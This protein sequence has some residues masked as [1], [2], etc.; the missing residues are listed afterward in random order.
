MHASGIAPAHNSFNAILLRECFRKRIQQQLMVTPVE[1]RPPGLIVSEGT[2]NFETIAPE[3]AVA[4]LPVLHK[5]ALLA[6]RLGL[7][8]AYSLIKKENLLQIPD[9]SDRDLQDLQ[10]YCQEIETLTGEV[11]TAQ[12]LNSFRV[13]RMLLYASICRGIERQ[14]HLTVGT[15]IGVLTAPQ[16]LERQLDT[17]Q[18]LLMFEVF[19]PSEIV[20]FRQKMKQVVKLFE[21]Y[22]ELALKNEKRPE[23]RVLL[24]KEIDPMVQIS[25]I[26]LKAIESPYHY[27]PRLLSPLRASALDIDRSMAEDQQ[28]MGSRAKTWLDDFKTV[29]EKLTRRFFVELEKKTE[30]SSEE[31]RVEVATG[32]EMLDP[33]LKEFAKLIDPLVR[34]LI[35]WYDF[36][37]LPAEK[38]KHKLEPIR[39]SKERFNSFKTQLLKIQVEYKKFFAHMEPLLAKVDKERSNKPGEIRLE[40]AFRGSMHVCYNQIQAL[41]AALMGSLCSSQRQYQ[42]FYEALVPLLNTP[43]QTLNHATLVDLLDLQTRTL[44]GQVKESFSQGLPVHFALCRSLQT[45][46]EFIFA[47]MR[48]YDAL[49]THRLGRRAEECGIDTICIEKAKSISSCAKY[50]EGSGYSGK[51]LELLKHYQI[52]SRRLKK[53]LSL[54]RWP[55]L[56]LHSPQAIDKENSELEEEYHYQ[57]FL[58]LRL[59]VLD[60][61]FL[62][63]A[64]ALSALKPKNATETECVAKVQ[65]ALSDC[66]EYYRSFQENM[67]QRVITKANFKQEAELLWQ[68]VAEYLETQDE[69]LEPVDVALFDCLSRIQSPAVEGAQKQ[70]V[71]VKNLFQTGFLSPFQTLARFLVGEELLRVEREEAQERAA[72]V[73]ARSALPKGPAPSSTSSKN[74]SE[75]PSVASTP[76]QKSAP[77]VK[78]PIVSHSLSEA[79]SKLE[80]LRADLHYYCQ[81]FTGKAP[82]QAQLPSQTILKKIPQQSSTHLIECLAAFRELAG[83]VSSYGDLSFMGTAIFL[84]LAAAIEQAA[85]LALAC[86]DIQAKIPQE[87]H[88]L[89]Q[90]LGKDCLWQQHDPGPL[91]TTLEVAFMRQQKRLLTDTQR[92]LIKELYAVL[93]VTYR[94][95]TSQDGLSEWIKKSLQPKSDKERLVIRQHLEEKLI[96]GIDA[97]VALVQ[98]ALP[99]TGQKISTQALSIQHMDHALKSVEETSEKKPQELIARQQKR[100]KEIKKYRT[101]AGK[102][103]VVPLHEAD[104]SC[105]RRQGTISSMLN[106]IRLT[107]S[108]CKDLLEFEEPGLCLTLCEEFLARR[109]VLFERILLLMLSHYPCPSERSSFEHYLWSENDDRLKR[110]SHE[111]QEFVQKLESLGKLPDPLVKTIRGLAKELVA[112]IKEEF[113]YYPALDKDH[114]VRAKLKILSILRERVFTNSLTEAEGRCLDEKLNITHPD[115]RLEKLDAHILRVHRAEVKTP[116]YQMLSLCDEFLRSYEMILLDDTSKSTAPGSKL[117]K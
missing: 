35:D 11:V 115:E 7:Q 29:F 104:A 37:R 54:D 78:L 17:L 90:R 84:K 79:F 45:D 100:I 72:E 50:L 51:A 3:I 38:Q 68:A 77:L 74:P 8:R 60:V 14:E 92:K 2:S 33:L 102:Q 31:I 9:L 12:Q 39:H 63:I 82:S 48:R 13:L 6:Q 83:S 67:K 20:A 10:A 88:A 99:P 75:A 96:T 113:R 52:L 87:G 27:L 105:V 86:S 22:R 64:D 58:Q 117:H 62:I 23:K 101:L 55:M 61:P 30:K 91:T 36:E 112:Y 4:Y 111:L 57:L 73:A 25:T 44:F 107:M 69:I 106:D 49:R 66:Q 98:S 108:L 97:I 53:V 40:L 32:K 1:S 76:L 41:M 59:G 93:G 70:L 56:F 95:P 109:S 94:Y 15:D 24:R 80:S 47:S 28:N 89:L 16:L 26:F 110:Y 116:L 19:D 81:G 85:K 114:P 46:V 65:K 18:Q 21:K 71:E 43:Y 42:K 34:D 5:V 103:D